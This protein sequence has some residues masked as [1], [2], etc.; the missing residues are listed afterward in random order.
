MMFA[1]MVPYALGGFAGPSLQ[2]IM[3]GQVPSNAQGEL[4]GALTSVISV[5][6]IIGPPLMTNMFAWFTDGTVGV[7]FPGAPFLLSAV[8]I[9]I[10]I[11]LA[12]KSLDAVGNS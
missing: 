6:S 11:V 2:G 5:T 4:Q 8:L 7:H 9:V 1:F 3:T 10:A 12:K